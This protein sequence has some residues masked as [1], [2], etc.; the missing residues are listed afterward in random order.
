M[1]RRQSAGCCAVSRFPR[2]LCPAPGP[3][4]L[5][6]KE[7][8]SKPVRTRILKLNSSTSVA[9]RRKSGQTAATNRLIEYAVMAKSKSIIAGF[10]VLPIEFPP[11]P[12]YPIVTTHYIY[13]RRNEPKISTPNEWRSLFVTNV[14]VDST[15]A[16]FR[17]IFAKLLGPGRFESISFEDG[18][19]RKAIDEDERPQLAVRLAAHGKKRKRDDEEKGSEQA[20]ALSERPQ[21]WSLKLKRTGSTAVVLLVDERSVELALRAVRKLHKAKKRITWGE[22]VPADARIPLGSQWLR[23]HNRLSYPDRAALQSSVDAF[24][25]VFNRREAE[26]AQLAKRLRSEPDEDGFVTVT[27]GGR[28]APA[29]KAEAEEARRKMEEKLERKKEQ[30]TDFYRFQTRERKKAEQD[31]L[32]K[33]VDEDRK[34]FNA[35]KERRRTFQPES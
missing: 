7:R 8:Q 26:A 9:D 2:L 24:F 25:A 21:T 20:V 1:V 16:H 30:M 19:N 31:E 12:S 11:L 10:S 35:M 33:R 23:A 6:D 15:D 28:N 4:S 29:R 22:G 5:I 17:A 3:P 14:P 18:V 32:L 27:R 13:L 34:K